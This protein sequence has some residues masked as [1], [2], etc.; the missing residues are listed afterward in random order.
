MEKSP[1]TELT[2][3]EPGFK[4]MY[5]ASDKGPPIRILDK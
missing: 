2:S 1:Q 3:Y 4:L 5:P